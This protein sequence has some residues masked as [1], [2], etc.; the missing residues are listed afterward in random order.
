M[1]PTKLATKPSKTA[2]FTKLDVRND[3]IV[4]CENLNIPGHENSVQGRGAMTDC[5]YCRSSGLFSTREHAVPESL[6]N[7]DLILSGQ[8]CD[9][10]QRYFGKEVEKYVLAKTP[11]AVWRVLLQIRTKKGAASSQYRAAPGG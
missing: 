8:V 9:A 7:D 1:P 4:T 3:S 6:G 11:L 2:V 5:L 10:C